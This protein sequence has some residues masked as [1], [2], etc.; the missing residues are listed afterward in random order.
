[1]VDFG[2]MTTIRQLICQNK[3]GF[4]YGLTPSDIYIMIPDIYPKRSPLVFLE[5]EEAWCDRKLVT[6]KNLSAKVMIKVSILSQSNNGIESLDIS[7]KI[8]QMVDGQIIP[9][10]DG[11]YAI[12]KLNSSI[13]DI[14]KVGDMPRKVEQYYEA[15][16]RWQKSVKGKIL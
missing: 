9:L 1:M 5:L 16:I 4:E 12:F 10:N 8:S 11:N 3:I 6:N 13:V 2:V 15:L 14:K 7:N